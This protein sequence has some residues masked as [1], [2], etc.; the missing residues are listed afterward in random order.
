MQKFTVIVKN[1]RSALTPQLMKTILK[2]LE[3]SKYYEHAA[4]FTK[5]FNPEFKGLIDI[6]AEEEC[7]LCQLFAETEVPFNEYK[8]LVDPKRKNFLS[9]MFVARKLLEKRKLFQFTHAFPLLKSREL[10]SKQCAWWKMVCECL[11]WEW[12]RTVGRI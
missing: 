5:R 1:G 6:P 7:M 8:H 12:V 3:L 11:G 10:L 2:R 9:Y 4:Y